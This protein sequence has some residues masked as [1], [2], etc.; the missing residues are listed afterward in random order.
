MKIYIILLT[1]FSFN[2]SSSFAQRFSVK[3]NKTFLDN[4]EFQVIGLRCSNALISDEIANGLIDQLD[5]YQN[6]GINTISVF[7]MGSRFGDIKGYNEDGT[8]NN[9][10]S[11]RMA[12]II[13]ACSKRNMVVLVGCL[14]WGNSKGKWENWTQKEA[15]S[16]V[17]N[18][19]KWLSDNK[20]YNVI[21]DPDNE[22]MANRAKGF[23]ISKMIAAGKKEDPAIIIGYNNHGYPPKNAD[24]ALHFA[25]PSPFLPYIESE[26]TMTDY[27]GAYSKEND[28]YHYI[29]VGIYTPGKKQE[30]I[31]TTDRLLQDGHGYIFASTWLQNVPVNVK[32]GGNGTH[33]DPG[34]SWWLDHIKKNYKK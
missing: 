12:R 4:K 24:V 13:E 22:G 28:V 31:E 18:T 15:N 23:D 20:Y 9:T 26:G 33:C 11:D 7:F 8:L 25:K 21:V 16:A 5:T 32:P 2:L 3:E 6:Y 1:I 17:A 10:Y 29:N 27:W 14:Y 34:I 19:V 30:Q